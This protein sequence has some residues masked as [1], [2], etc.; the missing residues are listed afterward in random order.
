MADY[1]FPVPT[2]NPKRN[3]RCYFGHRFRISRTRMRAQFSRCLPVTPSSFGLLLFKFEILRRWE[4][5]FEGVEHD[6]QQ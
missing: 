4:T 6:P 2:V 3:L 5:C 1:V